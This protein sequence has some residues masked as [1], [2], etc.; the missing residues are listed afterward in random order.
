MSSSVTKCLKCV[1]EIH[2]FFFTTGFVLNTSLENEFTVICANQFRFSNYKMHQ[3]DA[4]V[5]TCQLFVFVSFVH[6]KKR[7]LS[8]QIKDGDLV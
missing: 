7:S 4:T 1:L 2:I 8:R 5:C 3:S 6:V